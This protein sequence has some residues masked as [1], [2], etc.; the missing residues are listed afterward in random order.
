MLTPLLDSSGSR[1]L[2]EQIYRHIRGEI[3]AGRLLPGERLPS[4]RALA[5]HLK[6]SVVTVEGAYAQLLAEGYIRAEA[7]RGFFVLAAQAPPPPVHTL[8]ATSSLPARRCF[9]ITSPPAEWI[10]PSS[11]SP[12]GPS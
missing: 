3:E 2:Y 1:P 8:P 9:P 4:K 11:P 5:S 7:K 10:P 6:V 12:P